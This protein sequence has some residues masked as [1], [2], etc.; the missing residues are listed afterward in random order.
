MNP[1]SHRLAR[2][3]ALFTVGGGL[4]VLITWGLALSTVSL[5][6][7]LLLIVCLFTIEAYRQQHAAF[8]ARTQDTEREQKVLSDRRSLVTTRDQERQIEQLGKMYR[9]SSRLNKALVHFT[10]TE[11]LFKAICRILVETGDFKMAW[12]GWLNPATL[13]LDP[14]AS[15]GDELGYVPALHISVDP[16]QSD[17]HGPSG[18][19]FRTDRTYICHDF[20]HD[21][22]TGP[23]REAAARSGF[24]SSIALPLRLEGKT[25]GLLTVYA[26]E[27][28]FFNG[29]MLAIM[30]EASANISFALGVQA[31]A[32]RLRRSEARVQNLL[33][34]SPYPLLVTGLNNGIILYVNQPAAD[35]FE[36]DR[37]TIVG[38]TTHRF[39]GTPEQRENMLALVRRDGAIKNQEL[40]MTT[41]QGRNFHG[42]ISLNVAEFDGH[43]AA[44]ISVFDITLRKQAEAT[45]RLSEQRFRDLFEDVASVAVQ[46]YAPDGTTL[47]WNQASERLYGY[48]AQEAIGRSL[49]DLIIP[50][51]MR[52]GVAQAVR[53]AAEEG[54][55]IPA[56]ELCLQRKDGSRVDVY[57]S[58]VRVQLTGRPP[59]LFCLDIDL[60][61]H[62]KAERQIAE[63]RDELLRWQD[64]MQG[65][66]DRVLEM[67]QEVNELLHRL[68]EPARYPSAL[69]E[70]GENS[71]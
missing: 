38:T 20:A 60:T 33:N 47:Y 44:L 28:N 69:P 68:G 36:V 35:L 62:K 52:A 54:K 37:A 45:L 59:E 25:Q 41:A 65:R 10:S 27:L 1:T 19:A 4:F 13:C 70:A 67:K 55:P 66:E 49:L 53:A 5:I 26:T 9:C 43:Q 51:E 11:E 61:E 30:E 48:T 15:A 24:R 32:E 39:Y 3:A 34:Q 58:H 6:V 8:L 31:G 22:A 71:T 46:G 14:V 57:S 29:P 42:Q 64:A 7:G 63:Q 17:A 56:G 16:A 50:P 18:T 40:L 12:V 2:L 21:P 23:W